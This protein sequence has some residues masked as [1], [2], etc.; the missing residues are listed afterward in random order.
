[1][2]TEPGPVFHWDDV[3]PRH[4]VRPPMDATWTNLGGSSVTVGA[5]RIAL[6]PGCMPTPPHRHGAEEEIFYVLRGSGLSWQ[7]GE[8]FEVRAGDCLVHL[9]GGPAHTL[10]AG[11]DGLEVIAFGM[12][13][14]VEACVLPRP[15]VAFLGPARI[16]VIADHPWK[17][18]A[19]EPPLE[20]P[21]PSPRP[22]SL[23]NLADAETLEDN[24]R[25]V[26]RT[27]R[28]LSRSAGSVKTGLRHQ[29]VPAG[30][31]NCPPHCHSAEE[32]LFVVLEGGGT[33]LL[34]EDE[35]P[36]RAGSVVARPAGT[37]VAHAF[38]GG[39]E[40][41]E[42]LLYGTRDPNDIC[43]YPRSG[44][45]FLRGVGVIGRIEQSGYWDGEE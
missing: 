21:P 19:A 5:E 45:V 44:K 16:E 26:G 4:V 36:L 41:M 39:P 17:R 13:V 22:R 14:P 25:T 35:H 18:E 3:E 32:E 2:S 12:R 7:D 10:R 11:D 28:Y 6:E 20:F 8:A 43:F 29:T 31:L 34:G 24:H 33:L 40:G 38:R 42:L 37:G 15:G 30:M 23:V 27:I 1:M 9:A